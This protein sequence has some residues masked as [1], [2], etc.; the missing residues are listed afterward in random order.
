M[1]HDSQVVDRPASSRREAVQAGSIT[2]R[3]YQVAAVEAARAGHLRGLRRML[4]Q[5]PTGT[6]KTI[7][8]GHLAHRTVERGGRVLVVAHREELLAQAKRKM[9]LMNPAA[10]IGIV[11]AELD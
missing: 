6:G 7:L 4:V 1:P 10:D 2:L 8:F 5:L 11:R 9:L 3:P